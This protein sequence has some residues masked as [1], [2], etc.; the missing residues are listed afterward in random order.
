M[1]RCLH[2]YV[3]VF[4]LD[5]WFGEIL[6]LLARNDTMLHVNDLCCLIVVR[7]LHVNVVILS[8]RV[9]V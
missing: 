9:Y 5:L 2:V 3:V 7:C 4:F 1:F 6:I 8:F